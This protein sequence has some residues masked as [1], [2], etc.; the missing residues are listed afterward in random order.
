VDAEVS[1]IG[2]QRPGVAPPR[3][4]GLAPR[5]LSELRSGLRSGLRPDLQPNRFSRTAF[6]F[7]CA[8][9]FFGAGWCSPPLVLTRAR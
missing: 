1:V 2:G 4:P 6:Q 9:F 3:R 7:Y 5:L 8:R